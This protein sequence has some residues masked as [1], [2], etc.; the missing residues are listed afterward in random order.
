MFSN[1]SSS[2]KF[3]NSMGQQRE[4]VNRWGRLG[5]VE[6]GMSFGLSFN[7]CLTLREILNIPN[8]SFLIS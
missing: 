6:L 1:I 5:P 3:N 4:E 8:L 2:S 7:G